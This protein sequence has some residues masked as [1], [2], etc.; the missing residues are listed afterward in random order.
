MTEQRGG[1]G[2]FGVGK[3]N[4]D[5]V[6]C[7]QRYTTFREIHIKRLNFIGNIACSLWWRSCGRSKFVAVRT[8]VKVSVVPALSQDFA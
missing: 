6:D 1:P 3:G 4:D 8:V 7:G 2:S 5:C